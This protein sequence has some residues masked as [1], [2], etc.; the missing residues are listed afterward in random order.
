MEETLEKRVQQ[1]MK[2]RFET[3]ILAL[4]LLS[5]SSHVCA[6]AVRLIKS[7]AV[8]KEHFNPSLNETVALSLNI[9]KAGL[10][11]VKIIDRSKRYSG[12]KEESGRIR[13]VLKTYLMEQAFRL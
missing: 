13:K 6:E 8:S 1:P 4:L 10:L 9:S 11:D 2:K 7:V 12:F 3:L 5:L